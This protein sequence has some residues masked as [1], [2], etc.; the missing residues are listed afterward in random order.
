MNLYLIGYRCTGKTSVGKRLSENLGWE[1][2]DMDDEIAKDS[3]RSIAQLVKA[4]GWDY[5]R[6]LERSLIRRL[7]VRD[8]LV[9]ATGGGTVVEN[10]NA[11]DMK[12]SGKIIWLTADIGTIRRRLQQDQRS[13]TYRPSLTGDAVLDE[14]ETVLAQR[15]PI[16]RACMDLEVDTGTDGFD[17]VC[18]R[19]VRELGL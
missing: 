13:D 19:I 1:F 15:T 3:G 11:R 18:R 12:K 10:R 5:F 16:Y 4:H 8:H 14:I 6:K 7:C 17:A 9:V 2:V